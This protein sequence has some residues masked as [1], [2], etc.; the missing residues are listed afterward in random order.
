MV[1]PTSV[2]AEK[3]KSTSESPS[4]L[5]KVRERLLAKSAKQ[6][7]GEGISVPH[8][9]VNPNVKQLLSEKFLFTSIE[10]ETL[11]SASDCN[12]ALRAIASCL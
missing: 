4:L 7:E 10:P 8:Q 11:R 2:M 6:S 3:Q 9:E 1:R 5:S 12:E